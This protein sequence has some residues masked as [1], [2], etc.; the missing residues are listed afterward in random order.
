L[1]SA[2]RTHVYTPHTPMYLRL[3]VRLPIVLPARPRRRTTTAPSFRTTRSWLTHCERVSPC[4]DRP[5]YRAR[6]RRVRRPPV[7]A[8]ARK[9]RRGGGAMPRA[10]RGGRSN[11]RVL[12]ATIRERPAA[13][14]ARG[15]GGEGRRDGGSPAVWRIAAHVCRERRGAFGRRTPRICAG[16][17]ARV[18]RTARAA[19]LG[20]DSRPQ[21]G[22]RRKHRRQPAA[23]EAVDSEGRV[24]RTDTMNA[25][26]VP[27][28]QQ[29][30]ATCKRGQSDSE[31]SVPRGSTRVLGAPPPVCRFEVGA[32]SPVRCAS[33]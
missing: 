15:T 9:A 14:R 23:C 2:L 28:R 33:G 8:P 30:S 12:E 10:P 4:P 21:S 1:R 19:T 26:M 29:A 25:G 20:H 27:H 16:I 22:E 32:N 13:K 18:C 5:G 24:S 6:A 3:Q 11:V 17:A 7:F 31:W